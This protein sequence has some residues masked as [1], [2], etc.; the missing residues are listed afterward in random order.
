MRTYIYTQT[1]YCPMCQP[2]PER[3]KIQNPLNIKVSVPK[4]CPSCQAKNS[5]L[6]AELRAAEKVQVCAPGESG[7]DKKAH[8]ECLFNRKKR[9]KANHSKSRPP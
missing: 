7:R 5:Q 9:P 1:T 2:K 6:T 3:P 8:K 4:I